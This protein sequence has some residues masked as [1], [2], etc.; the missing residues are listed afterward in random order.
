MPRSSKTKKTKSSK[1]KSKSSKSK[2]VEPV[3][4]EV[5][6]K[7]VEEVP[8]KRTRRV[9]NRES[10]LAAHD[11]LL[12]DL[13]NEIEEIR[14]TADKK[15]GKTGIRFLKNI[16]TRLKRLKADS[17]RVIKQKKPSNR[18]KNSSSGFMKPVPISKEMCKFT[19][20]ETDVPKSRVDVTKYICNYIKE[21]D[22]QNPA[23]R[24]QIRPNSSLSKL[25]RMKKEEKEPLTYYS[26]QKKIQH[27]F[28]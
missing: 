13:N 26:L 7:V 5:V 10:V 3:V 11:S 21:H 20:W 19:G 14:K 1:S 9:V 15:K 18:A 2:P 12:V 28:K 22:L 6:E 27:H 4:E 23:D 24:R 16:V 25:L 17:A 8:V